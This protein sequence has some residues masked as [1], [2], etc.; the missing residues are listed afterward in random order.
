MKTS[1]KRSIPV[2]CLIKKNAFNKKKENPNE[3]KK[4]VDKVIEASGA[5]E[6]AR[7]ARE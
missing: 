7:T 1:K 5:R 4:V 6:A 2:A 3:K